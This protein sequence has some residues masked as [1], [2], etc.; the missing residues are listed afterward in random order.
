MIALAGK[1][2][3]AEKCPESAAGHG[4]VDRGAAA[5]TGRVAP[6]MSCDPK[7]R[8]AGRGLHQGDTAGMRAA[9]PDGRPAPLGSGGAR[10]NEI[11]AV[12]AA[13][14]QVTRDMGTRAQGVQSGNAAEGM[15][16]LGLSLLMMCP[17]RN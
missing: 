13:A 1:A 16:C 9:P 17:T 8:A 12:A 7:P 15:T 4:S 3:A 2:H 11:A 6:S 5:I 10:R 14:L